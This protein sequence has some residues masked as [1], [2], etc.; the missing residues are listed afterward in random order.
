MS[1]EPFVPPGP[2]AGATPSMPALPPPGWY[3]DPGDPA[4]ARFWDGVAWTDQVA[5]GAAPATPVPPVP[6]AVRAYAPERQSSVGAVF[7]WAVALVVVG[8][9][10][11]AVSLLQR[12]SSA[13]ADEAAATDV[14]ER[15]VADRLQVPASA[16]FSF[17]HAYAP[18]TGANWTVT[19][20][21][22]SV[23]PAG[24]LHRSTFTCTVTGTDN[25]LWHLVGLRFTSG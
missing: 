21:V 15:F 24:E 3:P 18:A 12:H 5:P 16:R 14:C 1:D 22:D 10:I 17:V 11:G 9:L 20:T 25:G 4:R 8:L 19:G 6:I 2:A 23:T 13:G 7:Y